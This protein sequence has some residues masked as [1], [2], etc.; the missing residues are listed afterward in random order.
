MYHSKLK[1][2]KLYI[3]AR[4]LSSIKLI[5]ID[6][7]NLLYYKEM[8]EIHIIHSTTYLSFNEQ[9]LIKQVD[10]NMKLKLSSVLVTS[11]NHKT[12]QPHIGNN[13]L[14]QDE[15]KCISP[16]EENQNITAD[17]TA[18]IRKNIKLKALNISFN[19][20]CLLE[21]KF[22]TLTTLNICNVFTGFSEKQQQA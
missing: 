15:I 10:L 12:F 20:I 18:I 2:R 16:S 19:S 13:N 4:R 8:K 21:L 14:N 7:K 3:N 11:S 6:L 22:T 9:Q 5:D 17:D 1:L